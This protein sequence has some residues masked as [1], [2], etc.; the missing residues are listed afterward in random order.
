MKQ[1]FRLDYL[2]RMDF[3]DLLIIVQPSIIGHVSPPRLPI[4]S[5]NHCEKEWRYYPMQE[6]RWPSLL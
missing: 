3:N 6:E 2:N 1:L 4:I 5:I